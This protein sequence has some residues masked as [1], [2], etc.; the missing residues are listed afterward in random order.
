MKRFIVAAVAVSFAGTAGA[1]S[2]STAELT[3]HSNVAGISGFVVAA[4]GPAL[5]YPATRFSLAAAGRNSADIASISGIYNG[6]TFWTVDVTSSKG[7]YLK[8][9]ADVDNSGFRY[10]V[11]W[12]GKHSQE[13]NLGD[14]RI[15][16]TKLGHYL[17]K[18]MP[19]DPEG[20]V[21]WEPNPVIEA[22]QEITNGIAQM[23]EYT[24]T[25]TAIVHGG[26]QW[27]MDNYEDAITVT[28]NSMP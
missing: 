23:A 25:L 16:T 3:V 28:F 11:D 8:P 21:N 6:S 27:A 10:A 18:N 15:G 19:A 4:L 13:A 17:K 1:F 14:A 22:T 5:N 20:D 7:F 12:A 26:Q 9:G 2:L 24:S